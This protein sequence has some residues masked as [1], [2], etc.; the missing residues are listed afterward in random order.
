MRCLFFL[1]GSEWVFL[2][3]VGITTAVL[4]FCMDFALDYVNR[5]RML[6]IGAVPPAAGYFIW[7]LIMAVMTCGSVFLTHKISPIAV[8]SGI[9]E[10]KTVLRNMDYYNT[11]G[12][13]SARTLIGKVIG[14]LL[15]KGSGLP[16]GKEG[17]SVHIA[18]A[19]ASL[20]TQWCGFF[21][22]FAESK[23]RRM[24]M[25]AAACA[26]G[27]AANFGAPIGGVLFSIEVTA[28]GYFAVRNYWRG[29]FAAVA[30]AFVFR[31]LAALVT[32]T[33]IT[34][35]FVTDFDDYP[36]SLF[37]L[38]AFVILGIVCGFFGALFV[39]VHSRVVQ[40][41]RRVARLTSVTARLFANKYAT[42]LCVVVVISTLTFPG[43]IGPFMAMDHK[44]A[45]LSL[46]S[47]K[48]LDC[49]GDTNPSGPW[50]GTSTFVALP[51]Y[52]VLN[53]FMVVVA[54]SLEIPCGVFTPIF[55]L[56]A[57]FGRLV[58]EGMNLWF[59]TGL[60]DALD[61]EI[62]HIC[63]WNPG[64]KVSLRNTA[65]HP[66]AYDTIYTH[67]SHEFTRIAGLPLVML[68]LVVRPAGDAVCW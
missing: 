66:P 9:P 30:G 43:V 44:Q 25:L 41:G 61:S 29:F 50:A 45:I 49:Y 53:F 35:L 27:V 6:A 1:F 57:G 39:F 3:S 60:S 13:L 16:I 33:N 36:Y 40:A 32:N 42:T 38:I 63:S 8:G 51:L 46:F 56:G 7:L 15:A 10:M 55:M 37:E 34:T 28:S 5:G 23:S 4:V 21:R 64:L 14:L 11:Q 65:I 24:E 67:C 58:G 19:L 68:P 62:S 31:L 22:H 59:P 2:A 52:I 48:P 26:V 20:M 17:P 12:Y 47:A 54:I 18:S